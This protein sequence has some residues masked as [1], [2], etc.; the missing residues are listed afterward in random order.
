MPLRSTT[1]DGTIFPGGSALSRDSVWWSVV[2]L[3]LGEIDRPSWLRI[4]LGSS[5]DPLRCSTVFSID[6]LCSMTEDW[7]SLPRISA[8]VFIPD[9]A[10]AQHGRE[11]LPSLVI[12]MLGD[13]LVSPSLYERDPRI[14]RMCELDATLPASP[15]FDPRVAFPRTGREVL[16]CGMS[17]SL[18]GLLA[19]VLL[20]DYT[21]GVVWAGGNLLWVH[22]ACWR[23]S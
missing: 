13:A 19:N 4:T 14:G 10:V 17:C 15:L 7:P 18:C 12:E 9:D 22:R 6:V 11:N 3:L 8:E 23:R 1:D 21:E 2:R 16:S 20:D 5:R